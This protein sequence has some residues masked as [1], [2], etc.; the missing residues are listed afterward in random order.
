MRLKDDSPSRK[1]AARWA[2]ALAALAALGTAAIAI[3][4]GTARHGTAIPGMSRGSA[5][6]KCKP[7]TTA[8]AGGFASPGFDPSNNGN[9][10]A[11]VSSKLVGKH[12]VKTRGYNFGRQPA[13]LVSLAYCVKHGRGLYVRSSKVFVGPGS[14]GSAVARC[15]PGT[16]AV[17]GGFGTPGFSTRNG[18]R[19]LTLTSRRAGRRKW[20]VEALNMRGDSSPGD[21]RPGALLAYA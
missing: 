3:G 18:P 19:V 6:A 2:L 17:G 9:G 8:V 15:R 5:T 10:V 11:R 1:A 4:A 21:D 14:A 16:E 20:R 13:D 12:S 7:G